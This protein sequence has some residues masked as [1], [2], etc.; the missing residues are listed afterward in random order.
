MH[1]GF[2]VQPFSVSDENEPDQLTYRMEKRMRHH[3]ISDAVFPVQPAE[4]HSKA[5]V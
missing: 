1:C 3:G 2:T 4:E 5:S